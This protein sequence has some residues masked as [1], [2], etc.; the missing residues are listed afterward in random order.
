MRG[1]GPL[2]FLPP[3]E[4]CKIILNHFE[5]IF[6]QRAYRS[7]GTGWLLEK[8]YFQDL[9]VDVHIIDQLGRGA[10]P[11]PFLPSMEE[12]KIILNHSEKMF[13]QRGYRNAGIGWLLEKLYFQDLSVDGHIIDQLGRGAGPLPFLPSMEDCKIILNHSGKNVCLRIGLKQTIFNKSKDKSK[14]GLHGMNF[15]NLIEVTTSNFTQRSL[16]IPF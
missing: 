12:C 5:K 11:L 9:S 1:A 6:G 2:P 7:T 8:L 14:D 16:S 10:G 4:E 15:Q 13:G 3:M